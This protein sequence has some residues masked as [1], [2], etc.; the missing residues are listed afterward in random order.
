MV[1]MQYALDYPSF[2]TDQAD[3]GKVLEWADSTLY[4][5][6]KRQHNTGVTGTIRIN[7]LTV[8]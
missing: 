6:K 1:T 7:Y 4:I 2:V 8:K 5:A 3:H